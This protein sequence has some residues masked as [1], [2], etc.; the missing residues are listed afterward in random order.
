MSRCGLDRETLAHKDSYVR[1]VKTYLE[2][3]YNEDGVLLGPVPQGPGK[4]PMPKTALT[5]KTWL[6]TTALWK[7]E[8]SLGG[9]PPGAVRL[10]LLQLAK[11][12]AVAADSLD[13]NHQKVHFEKQV[14]VLSGLEAAFTSYDPRNGASLEIK[15]ADR[16]IA[17]CADLAGSRAG[18]A[19][20]KLDELEADGDQEAEEEEE[21]NA[22]ATV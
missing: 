9:D 3:L 22:G 14:K 5:E 18:L 15:G 1:Q 19:Q 8:H 16:I 12:D 11:L 21:E 10:G 13:E 7:K 20:Q 6:T 4:T 2:T 17:A